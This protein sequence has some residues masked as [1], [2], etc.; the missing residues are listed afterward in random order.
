MYI[1]PQII[2][3]EGTVFLVYSSQEKG[4]YDTAIVIN[5]N[6]SGKRL[7]ETGETSRDWQRSGRL[8]ETG[9]DQGD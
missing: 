6:P 3:T 7:E 1:T 2:A 5:L 4:H 8:V 9:R